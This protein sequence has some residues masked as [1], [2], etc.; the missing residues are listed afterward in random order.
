MSPYI[1]CFKKPNFA[2]LNKKHN[3]ILSEYCSCTVLET[4]MFRRKMIKWK[5]HLSVCTS[6]YTLANTKKMINCS[7]NTIQQQQQQ[8]QQQNNNNNNKQHTVSW[9]VY[10][11]K[12]PENKWKIENLVSVNKIWYNY[13]IIL[14]LSTRTFIKRI[15]YYHILYTLLYVSAL[16]IPHSSNS[17]RK[18]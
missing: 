4:N 9:T 2:I 14:R 8:Q 15:L 6:K 10:K 11:R 12:L 3:H 16:N 7:T 5:L 1:Q 17:S 18:K 13:S